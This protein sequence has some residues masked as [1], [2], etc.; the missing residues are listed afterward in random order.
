MEAIPMD[1][2]KVDVGEKDAKILLSEYTI[3]LEL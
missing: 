1:T 3:S 2:H